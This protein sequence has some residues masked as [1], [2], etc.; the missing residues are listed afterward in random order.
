[1]KGAQKKEP[2][3]LKQD[4]A[5]P[6]PTMRKERCRGWQCK[7]TMKVG[8]Q[9][10]L[11]ALIPLPLLRYKNV[12]VDW[13][14]RKNIGAHERVCMSRTRTRWVARASNASLTQALSFVGKAEFAPTAVAT[15]AAKET[16]VTTTEE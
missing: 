8:P 4:V 2:M 1:M 16:L 9:P 3:L 10:E 11:L 14:R 6:R 7:H 5:R 12:H 15:L 13:R